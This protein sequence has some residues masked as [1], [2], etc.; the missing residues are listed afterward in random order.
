[1]IAVIVQHRRVE[2]SAGNGVVRGLAR[3]IRAIAVLGEFLHIKLGDAGLD[4]RKHR[5]VTSGGDVC[6]ALHERD[7]R[8]RLRG[9]HDCE[10]RG[11]IN[12]ARARDA[13]GT[14]T[15]HIEVR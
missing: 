11:V 2:S 15:K 13:L 3:A 9:A 10:H 4:S 8:G 1:M 6:G 14:L 7:F 12:D 5:G